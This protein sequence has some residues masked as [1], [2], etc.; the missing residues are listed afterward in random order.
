MRAIIIDATAR[1]IREVE[2]EGK[3]E[4]LQKAVGGYIE[5]ATE[6]DNGDNVYVDEEGLLKGYQCFFDIGAHQPFAGNAIVVNRDE[7]G[8]TAAAR[9]D[10][11]E[12]RGKVKFMTMPEARQRAREM[13]RA[14]IKDVG[15]DALSGNPG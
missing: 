14:R 6:L 4:D 8:E 10:V 3:L 9:S 7:D 12:I 1:E 2:I 5:W 13:E 15:G 11:E